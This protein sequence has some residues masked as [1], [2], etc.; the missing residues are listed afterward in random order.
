MGWKKQEAVGN[1][2]TLGDDA[3]S[4][5]AFGGLLLRVEQNTMYPQKLDYI[6]VK[7]NGEVV[8]L[9]GSASLARQLGPA[10]VGQFYKAEFLGWGKSANGKFK[11]IA[12]HLWDGDLTPDMEQW[13]ML[14]EA[15]QNAVKVGVAQGKAPPPK[16]QPKEADG[17]DDFP[18]ALADAGATGDD[19]DLPF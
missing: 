3:E 2:V 10:H 14:H 8:R 1:F 11:E 16:A 7:K 17:F 15:R 18:E 4:V 12:V 5:K 13:P 9:S 19:S 6:T